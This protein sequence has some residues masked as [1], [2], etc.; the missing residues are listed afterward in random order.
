MEENNDVELSILLETDHMLAMLDKKQ[1]AL[2]DLIDVQDC[3]K[4]YG[5]TPTLE[6]LFG[7]T[8]AEHEIV[9]H[10]DNTELLTTLDKLVA[11]GEEAL[12]GHLLESFKQVIKHTEATITLLEKDDSALLALY[13]KASKMARPV[14]KKDIVIQ[15]PRVRY[16]EVVRVANSVFNNINRMTDM[17]ATNTFKITGEFKSMHTDVQSG[18]LPN[19][20]TSTQNFS[21]D[22]GESAAKGLDITKYY[23]EDIPS[24]IGLCKKFLKK[25][26]DIAKKELD[27]KFKFYQRKSPTPS[28]LIVS[29]LRAFNLQLSYFAARHAFEIK[30]LKNIEDK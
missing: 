28:E 22:A 13:K 17:L 6:R 12:S 16:N 20:F 4:E 1:T 21:F 5:V 8:F 26:Q 18:K 9:L 7:E 15:Y 29:H 23:M 19:L 25:F 11:I 2:S 10:A 14:Y 30:L 24:I 27:V 3:V